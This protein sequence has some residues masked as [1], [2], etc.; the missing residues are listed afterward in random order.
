MGNRD[1][2]I[3]SYCSAKEITGHNNFSS[4]T[5]KSFVFPVFGILVSF[6]LLFLGYFFTDKG[7]HIPIIQGDAMLTLSTYKVFGK[8]SYIYS[9]IFFF[10]SIVF[11]LRGLFYKN[12]L[13]SIESRKSLSLLQD[14]S[15][16]EF[17]EYIMHLFEELG[18]SLENKGGL[19]AYSS[20]LKITREGRMS[21]V[22][23]KKYYV[24]KVPLSMVTEFY[25]V[26]IK[27][28]ELEKGYFIT[29]GSFSPEARKFADS[30]PIELIDSVRLMDFVRIADSI[31]SAKERSPIKNSPKK[32]DYRC[33]RCGGPM[34]LRTFRTEAAAGMQFWGCSAY[35]ACKGTLRMEQGEQ[36]PLEY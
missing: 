33:P 3:D 18:Y 19:C 25:D 9:G 26:M 5:G 29:T 28:P 36:G 1:G 12:K 35:P 30:K 20:D 32:S 23:C 7:M 34:T 11:S 2:L 15:W 24:R 14:L 17:E 13:S 27:E 21:L 8:F 31:K 16:K 6:A 4:A 22:R 10:G